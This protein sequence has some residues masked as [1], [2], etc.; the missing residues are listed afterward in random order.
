MVRSYQQGSLFNLP[1]LTIGKKIL[2]F[3]LPSFLKKSDNSWHGGGE[4]KQIIFQV[5]SK[6]MSVKESLTSLTDSGL[7]GPVLQKDFS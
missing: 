3:S 6:S 1:L 5:R 2:L 4:L 7:P